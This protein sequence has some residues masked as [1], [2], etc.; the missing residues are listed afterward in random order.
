MKYAVLLCELPGTGRQKKS[1]E[2]IEIEEAFVVAATKKAIHLRF[3][4]SG[5]Q[6]WVARSQLC[7][8]CDDGTMPDLDALST[9]GEYGSVRIP[10]FIAKKWLKGK[11]PNDKYLEEGGRA[12]EGAAP[13][14]PARNKSQQP[15]ES[16]E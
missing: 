6:E 4:C 5:H 11:R 15:K 10:L 16:G 7:G 2:A 3:P 12:G 8:K 13:E 1:T 9:V 14:E